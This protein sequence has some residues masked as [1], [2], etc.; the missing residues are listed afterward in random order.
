[1]RNEAIFTWVG[2]I[3]PRIAMAA[4]QIISVPPSV[5]HIYTVICSHSIIISLGKVLDTLYHHFLW[6]LYHEFVFEV[7]VNSCIRVSVLSLGTGGL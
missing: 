3:G 5:R 2:A 7:G 6:R 1:M 4:S